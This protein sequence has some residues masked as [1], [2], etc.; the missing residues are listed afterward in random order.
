MFKKYFSGIILLFL[1]FSCLAGTIIMED[2]PTMYFPDK[3]GV[4]LEVVQD[5]V[6]DAIDRS[7]YPQHLW[8]I[9]SE[10]PGEIIARLNVRSHVLRMK[11]TFDTHKIDYKYHDSVRLKYSISNAGMRRIH[12]KYNP[13]SEF[14]LTKIKYVV[15]RKT[16]MSLINSSPITQVVLSESGEVIKPI[17][18]VFSVYGDTNTR[19]RESGIYSDKAMSNAMAIEIQKYLNKVKPVNVN[20]EKINW[21]RNIYNYMVKRRNRIPVNL[22]QQYD[23]DVL[24]TGYL[25][26]SLGGTTGSRDMHYQLY[27]C[28][29]EDIVK[30]KYDIVDSYE[31]KFAYH[32]EVIKSLK[33]FIR[34][35]SPFQR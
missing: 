7:S 29:T 25:D 28:R 15:K 3:K 8:T 13:W 32:F 34:Q 17:R 30:Q 27:T 10:K 31:E 2:Y 33:T 16:K 19:G 21:N 35:Y 4:K 9:D 11:I 26:D 1:S 12:S 18:L 22:C 6:A 20:I 14:L 5:I 24:L 23:A